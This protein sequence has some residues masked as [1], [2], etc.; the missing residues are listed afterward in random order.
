MRRN[1]ERKKT[2]LTIDTLRQETGE[3]VRHVSI[4]FAETAVSNPAI[5]S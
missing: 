3:T 2:E 1:K 4:Y 5:T